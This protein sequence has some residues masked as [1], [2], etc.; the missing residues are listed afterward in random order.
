MAKSPL[1]ISP[2]ER[3]RERWRAFFTPLITL[4][5]IVF[6]V[7]MTL[8]I[9]KSCGARFPHLPAIQ[10]PKPPSPGPRA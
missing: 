6:S 8:A 4:A 1:K 2:E 9:F 10:Q 7:A 3:R 5:S